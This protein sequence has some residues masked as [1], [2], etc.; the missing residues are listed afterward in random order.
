MEQAEKHWSCPPVFTMMLLEAAEELSTSQWI[1]YPISKLS[2]YI[3]LS[4]AG[5]P[6]TAEVDKAVAVNTT[7]PAVELVVRLVAVLASDIVLLAAVI[8]DFEVY[9]AVLEAVIIVV[10]FV[11][12]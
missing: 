10:C 2:V 11:I 3:V 5:Q 9:V 6:G 12:E 4:P 1:T 8:T 7:K